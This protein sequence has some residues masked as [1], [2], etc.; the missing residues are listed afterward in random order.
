MDSQYNLLSELLSDQ[1]AFIT[2]PKTSLAIYW[3]ALPPAPQCLRACL[4]HYLA[5]GLCNNAKYFLQLVD[6]MVIKKFLESI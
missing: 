1:A 4:A 5:R 6:S 2:S 3:G